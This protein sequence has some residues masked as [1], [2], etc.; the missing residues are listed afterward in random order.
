MGTFCTVPDEGRVGEVVDGAHKQ[1][2]LV[3]VSQQ[4]VNNLLSFLAA[5]AVAMVSSA[6]LFRS[7]RDWAKLCWWSRIFAGNDKISL[8]GDLSKL[9][10][11]ATTF[12][13]K[14]T[15]DEN[16][17]KGWTIWSSIRGHVSRFR[18]RDRAKSPAGS[19][20]NSRAKAG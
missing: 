10:R 3:A 15:T 12:V 18:I 14:Y 19:A 5:T 4:S 2:H 17:K 1:A 16:E 8:C 9:G 13:A 20:E 11:H 7:L 6:S